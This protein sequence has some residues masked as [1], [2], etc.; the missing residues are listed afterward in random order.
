MKCP[1]VGKCEWYSP[2][3]PDDRCNYWVRDHGVLQCCHGVAKA[4]GRMSTYELTQS[5]KN[6]IDKVYETDEL[7]DMSPRFNNGLAVEVARV[8]RNTAREMD[9]AIRY[10]REHG[11]MMSGNGNSDVERD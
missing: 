1:R 3:P 11:V 7:H 5:L 2:I 10:E 6:M 9:S 4:E 8:F